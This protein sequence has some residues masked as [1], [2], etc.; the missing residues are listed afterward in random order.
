M[1]S[2]MC[3]RDR[4]QNNVFATASA[5]IPEQ[6]AREIWGDGRAVV[7]NGPPTSSVKALPVDGGYRI[8]GRWNFSTGSP[9]ATWLAALVPMAPPGDQQDASTERA[10]ARIMLLPKENATILDTWQVSGLRG[11]G[12]FS[13][14][15]DDL[16][17]PSAR[18][19]EPTDPPREGGPLYVIPRTLLFASGDATIALGIARASLNTVSYTHLT[20]PTILLV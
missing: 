4:N 18:T 8:S 17:V 11:T 14:E 19:Y 20:L 10:N 7:S 1:G 15:V 16:Y 9:H 6:T 12:S 3:I 5:I 13:F 2:E